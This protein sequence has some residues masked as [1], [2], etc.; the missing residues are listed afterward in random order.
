MPRV[1]FAAVRLSVPLARVLELLAFAPAEGRGDQVRGPCPVHKSGSTASR[2]FSANLAKNAFRCIACGAAGNQID[3]WAA[4]QGLSTFQAAV[5]LCERH[6]IAVP[7]LDGDST[8][9]AIRTER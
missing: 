4:V 1:D 7:W 9:R 8:P 6:G 5:D 2:S 3:L